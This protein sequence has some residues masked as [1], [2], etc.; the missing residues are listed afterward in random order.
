MIFAGSEVGGCGN[1][2]AVLCKSQAGHCCGVSSDATARP[3]GSLPSQLVLAA[4]QPSQATG[5]WQPEQQMEQNPSMSSNLCTTK[6]NF[7]MS[8][9]YCLVCVVYIYC[10]CS[11]PVVTILV[12]VSTCAGAAVFNLHLPSQSCPAP[13]GL[14]IWLPS[15]DFRA[16]C[17]GPAGLLGS[18]GRGVFTTAASQSAPHSCVTTQL[19]ARVR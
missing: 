11:Y 10:L 14:Q 15:S 13:A 6:H 9:F 5:N 16:Q 12:A 7:V 4:A 18:C 8:S 17:S 2:S 3:P 1:P 19:P